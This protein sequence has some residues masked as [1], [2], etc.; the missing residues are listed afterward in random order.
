MYIYIYIYII[1]TSTQLQCRTTSLLC[2]QMGP[3]LTVHGKKKKKQKNPGNPADSTL[4]TNIVE[5]TKRVFKKSVRKT[6]QSL[7]T[8][9][10]L[11]TVCEFYNGCYKSANGLRV[12][13]VP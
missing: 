7:Q 2:H 11:Q 12:R 13:P 3:F 10:N 6:H 1:Y 8:V 4:S 9:A 5:A